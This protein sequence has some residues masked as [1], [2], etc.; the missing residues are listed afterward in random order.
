MNPLLA[1]TP[2]GVANRVLPVPGVT[3]GG[4]GV[5]GLYVE[6]GMAANVGTDAGFGSAAAM[7]GATAPEP[8]FR[9]TMMAAT[10]ATTVKGKAYFSSC[11][12]RP[13][14]EPLGLT[15]IDA[16]FPVANFANE[17]G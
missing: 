3:G 16:P 7:V 1:V 6:Y 15:K 2:V 17:S 8:V 13:L 14:I 4:V 10:L 9:K 5:A 12:Y 11:I